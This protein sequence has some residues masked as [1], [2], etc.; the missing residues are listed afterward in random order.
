V[1]CGRARTGHVEVVVSEEEDRLGLAWEGSGKVQGRF[2]EEEDR[3]GLAVLAC[4]FGKLLGLVERLVPYA[5]QT[6]GE[7]RGEASPSGDVCARSI[8]V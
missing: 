8:R 7:C 2:R 5:R 1:C 6:R 3:L 4:I